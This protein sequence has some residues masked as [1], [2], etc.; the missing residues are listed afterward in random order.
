MVGSAVECLLVLFTDIFFEEALTT[1]KAPNSNPSVAI[2]LNNLAW[3]L[4]DTNRLAEAEPL[5]RRALAINEKSFGPEHLNVA[6]SLNNLAWLLRDTNRLAEAEPLFGK[7]LQILADFGHRTGHEHAH[8]RTAIDNY[9]ELIS[10]ISLSQDEILAR[11]R[12]AIESEP[13]ELA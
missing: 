10:A 9:T 4:R 12:S 5:Y 13:D 11:L 1:G 7:A 6:T 3:L 8:F 2:S